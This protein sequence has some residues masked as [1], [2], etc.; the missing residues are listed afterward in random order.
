MKYFRFI[1]KGIKILEFREKR[2]NNMFKKNLEF[3]N[4]NA[5]NSAAIA[6]SLL[7]STFQR[8]LKSQIYN[9]Y[10]I[11]IFGM[12]FSYVYFY[13]KHNYTQPVSFIYMNLHK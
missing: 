8:E 3:I 5:E 9:K 12:A 1:L 10:K 13:I 6:D 11:W 4:K 2:F 7:F